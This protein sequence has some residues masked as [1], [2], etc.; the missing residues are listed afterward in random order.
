MT[1][2]QNSEAIDFHSDSYRDA[3]KRVNGIVLE[4]EQQA[5]ENFV[6]LAELLPEHQTE[7]LRLAKME[8]GHRKSF[9]ACGRNLNVI[10]D[11]DFA[12]QF[13]ADLHQVFQAAADAKQIAT[14]LVVQALVIECFAIAAYNQYLPVADD[15]AKKITASVVKDEYSHLNFGEVWLKQSFAQVKDEM[16]QA[17]QQVMPIVWRMLKQAEADMKILGMAKIAV[18]DDFIGRYSETLGQ[19]GF[20]TREILRMSIA[21]FQF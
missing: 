11:L 6:R 13:F 8:A 16:I 9:E 1:H 7:L 19:I 12:R 14:C 4:G 15:F 20:S 18:I 3:Y 17:N 10:P 2:L 5:Y 21:S